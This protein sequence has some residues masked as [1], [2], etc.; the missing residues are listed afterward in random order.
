MERCDYFQGDGDITGYRLEA[1]ED[2]SDFLQCLRPMG[3]CGPHLVKRSPAR[4][5]TFYAWDKVICD[6]CTCPCIDS[7]NW[8]DCCIAYHQPSHREI[9]QMILDERYEP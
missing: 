5:G 3:H 4:G 7:D 2:D 9:D 1:A 6:D 8:E